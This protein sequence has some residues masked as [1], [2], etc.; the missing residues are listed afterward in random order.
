MP[1][2]YVDNRGVLSTDLRYPELEKTASTCTGALSA[3]PRP[4]SAP[5][6]EHP[7]WPS[8]EYLFFWLHSKHSWLM[9]RLDA[10]LVPVILS[11]T[12]STQIT[13]MQADSTEWA[14]VVW[15]CT[16]NKNKQ[17]CNADHESKY[18]HL[19]KWRKIG[20]ITVVLAVEFHSQAQ[21]PR[22][23]V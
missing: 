22:S 5:G 14:T 6:E 2:L 3:G 9:H 18:C 8:I 17:C 12:T 19:F 1:L 16:H 15:K 4:K 21:H 23:G 7:Q 11:L 10:W 20:W 13:S